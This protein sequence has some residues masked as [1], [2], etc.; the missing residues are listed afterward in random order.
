MIVLDRVSYTYPFQKTKALNGIDIRVK[1]GELVL[2]TGE[3]GCGKSTIARVVNGLI[4]HYFKGKLEGSVTVNGRDTVETV[5]GEISRSVGTLFQDPEQQ[6]FCT[7]VYSELAFTEEVR[8]INPETVSETVSSY[9]EKY[10][11]SH[12]LDSSIY[13]LSEG[14]KQKVALASIMVPE[15]KCLV[16]D[17]P[18][19]NLSPEATEKLAEELIQLKENGYAVLVVDH[20][21]YWLDGIADRVMVMQK[22]CIVQEGGFDILRSNELRNRYGLRNCSVSTVPKEEGEFTEGLEIKD[23][24]FAY[25]KKPP[26][27]TNYSASVQ[28]GTVTALRGP[29]GVGKTTLSRLLTGLLKAKTGKI[30]LN[31]KELKPAELLEVTSLVLQ[32]MDHQLY[33]STVLEEVNGRT[34][35]LEMLRLD[36]FAERHPQSLSGGQKQRLVIAA[37]LSRDPRVIILDEPTSGLDGANMD[38]IGQMLRMEAEKGKV[39][40]VITHDLEFIDRCCNRQIEMKAEQT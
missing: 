2:L 33:S 3:S 31:E 28:A 37:A 21:L 18:S 39:I 10:D 12:V 13:S 23:L 30:F 38:I 9:A 29:N 7:D 19:A 15:P 40:M 16:L 17:E 20:R 24:S 34:G 11:I 27:F 36:R 22:G 26:I 8:G 35:I 6:F 5:V 32:N 25:G 1:P 14:E 4:P